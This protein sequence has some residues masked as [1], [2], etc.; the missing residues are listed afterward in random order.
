MEQEVSHWGSWFQTNKKVEFTMTGSVAGIVIWIWFDGWNGQ[1]LINLLPVQNIVH[2]RKR[3]FCVMRAIIV[4]LI[5]C[6]A[7]TLTHLIVIA[8]GNI[9]PWHADFVR[10]FEVKATVSEKYRNLQ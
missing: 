7:S 10:L 6:H 8:L 4:L 3:S 1:G 5:F 9:I 2:R